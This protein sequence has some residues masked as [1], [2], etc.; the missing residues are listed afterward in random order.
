LL[1]GTGCAGVSLGDHV[2]HCRAGRGDRPGDRSRRSRSATD[3]RIDGGRSADEQQGPAGCRTEQAWIPGGADMG[4]CLLLVRE[5][6]ELVA[7]NRVGA[8]NRRAGELRLS[9]M[10]RKMTR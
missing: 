5:R 7:A 6:S 2:E 9:M 1:L 8:P 3:V 4:E 10:A